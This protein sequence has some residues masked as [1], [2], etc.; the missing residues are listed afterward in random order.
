MG[1]LF[2]QAASFPR[3][4]REDEIR[5]GKA[6]REHR[7]GWERALFSGDVTARYVVRLLQQYIDSG[8]RIDRFC[9][10]LPG[11]Q[12]DLK[13]RMIGRVEIIKANLKTLHQL[14]RKN[15]ELYR[16]AVSKRVPISQRQEAWRRLGRNKNKVAT[17]LIECKLRFQV[18]KQ[19]HNSSKGWVENLL[20][21]CAAEQD[22]SLSAAK[23]TDP[24]SQHDARRIVIRGLQRWCESPRSLHSRFKQCIRSYDDMVASMNELSTSNLLLVASIAK[25]FDTDYQGKGRYIRPFYS[26][27]C[28]GLQRAVEKFD[29]RRCCKFST[30]ATPWIKQ[31]VRREIAKQRSLIHVPSHMLAAQNA[32]C[33]ENAP[34]Q[35]LDNL[36]AATPKQHLLRQSLRASAPMRSL[37]DRGADDIHRN[38]FAAILQ[39][40]DESVEQA[41]FR[42]ELRELVHRAIKE[43]PLTDRE[44]LLLN[45]RDFQGKT[46]K[47]CA[48]TFNVTRE[49]IRQIELKAH[50][51]LERHLV[52]ALGI[53]KNKDSTID[54]S[55]LSWD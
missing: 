5:I 17:L 3:L 53:S 35:T 4:K 1:S 19:I 6:I 22:S 38:G 40:P 42:L 16:I 29:W 23:A 24:V 50:G 18:L 51:K 21:R 11:K 43:A 34:I 9:D 20:A 55:W 2:K 13:I 10:P 28:E 31:S 36:E 47:E 39:A 7:E 33:R 8:K 15:G 52:S 46:L 44:R 12:K 14:L 45:L 48:K 37:D 32:H 27:G 54:P 49:R 26:A 41:A 25:D 30:I